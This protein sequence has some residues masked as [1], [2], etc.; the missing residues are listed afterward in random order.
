MRD[1]AAVNSVAC[2]LMETIFRS[3]IDINC[4]S[5]T[6]DHVGEHVHGPVAERFVSALLSMHSQSTAAR[7][8][9]KTAFGTLPIS[10]SSTRWWSRWEFAS[11]VLS[12][13]PDIDK[14]L[15]SLIE[16]ECCM[17]YVRNLQSIL[18]DPESSVRLRIQLTALKV[19]MKPFVAATYNVEGDSFLLPFLYDILSELLLICDD[20]TN[21]LLD[22]GIPN[23]DVGECVECVQPALTYFRQRLWGDC[24]SKVAI[25]K[26]ARMFN[27]LRIL[28]VGV[29]CDD[30]LTM[31]STFPFPQL[32]GDTLKNLIAELP[33]YKLRAA[34]LKAPSG[35]TVSERASF[36]WDWWSRQESALPT[37]CS[38]C[39]IVCLI[40][41]SS[42]SVERVFSILNRM[43]GSDRISLIDYIEG[44][45]MLEYN[46]R[47]LEDGRKRKKKD[48]M[49]DDF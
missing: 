41:P 6:L 49:I 28:D 20:P 17:N 26:Y 38:V 23:T 37:W 3:A 12:I 32:R 46:N 19:C 15:R 30:I 31:A 34:E 33:V 43:F 7:C 29:T 1:S 35:M 11:S 14:Y 10:V 48:D 5:H 18:D 8:Y 21:F 16:N 4:F 42:A 47:D 40:Q 27:P 44:C 25:A 39:K 36:I 22:E 45:V 9:W 13:L 2:T 24:R